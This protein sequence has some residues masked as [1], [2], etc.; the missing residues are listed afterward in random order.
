MML[1]GERPEGLGE[2]DLLVIGK[3]DLREHQ[4]AALL[5]KFP[6]P[7]GMFAG[8][9]RGLVGPDLGSDARLDVPG[10]EHSGHRHEVSSSPSRSPLSRHWA[11]SS[12]KA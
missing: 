11:I 10:I 2:R 4:H 8:E 3:S 6:Y 5:Q 9:Q 12:S 7:P 1:G